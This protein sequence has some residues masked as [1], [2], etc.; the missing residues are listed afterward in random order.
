MLVL[1]HRPARGGLATA[2]AMAL[3]LAVAAPGAAWGLT[4]AEAWADFQSLAA[5]QGL[6]VTTTNV[7]S[8]PEAVTASGVRL[9][10]TDDPNA[11][12]ISMDQ[13]V[14]EGRDDLISLTP[15]ARFDVAV[16]FAGGQT[17]HFTV[18]HDGGLS[19]LLN[20]D[21]AVLN[22]D[23]PNLSVT[24]EPSSAPAGKGG[25]SPLAVAM[26]FDGLAASLR[27]AREGAAEITIDA[28]SVNYD[29]TYPDPSSE[30]STVTQ[31]GTMQAP[32]IAFTGTELDLLEG[33]DQEGGLR[34]AFDGGFSASLE[35][36]TAGS[37]QSSTQVMEGQNLTMHTLGGASEMR[38][39]AVDGRIDI[40]GTADGISAN[41]N[42]GP[43]AGGFDLAGM[44]LNF[45]LPLVMTP[46]D[47]PIRYMIALDDL[48]IS[49]ELLAMLGAGQF[50][51]D[52]LSVALDL[53]A[54]GRL[55]RELGPEFGEGDAP[56]FDL[57]TA[58]L[59][60]LRLQVGDSA[61]TGAGAVTLVGGI[62]GQIV[63]GRPN[64]D[65]RFL[66]DLVGGER[67]LTR[68]QAMGLV[69]QDQLF[70]MRMMINGMGRP[71]GEDHLQSEVVLSSAGGVTVNGAPLPF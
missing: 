42:F 40:A 16:L 58:S 44:R 57:S 32:H 71:V 34:A 70:F 48:A 3:C 62:M 9:F 56:P 20:D 37:E 25:G 2:T 47:Q 46:E 52:R 5:R 43:I 51:G 22:L 67:L 30:R 45:G 69:P 26:Q 12:T 33:L 61:F 54:Q 64:A 31:R 49:P 10:P 14:V 60:D 21:N 53:G 11:L 66:F 35:V 6:S 29:L 36:T 28:G 39:D 27:A 41:G 59:N 18:T 1:T 15:S 17:R 19:G 13:L 8:A 23:F 68:V 63:G 4:A 7:D 38:I 55:T 24:L 50:A 65:G